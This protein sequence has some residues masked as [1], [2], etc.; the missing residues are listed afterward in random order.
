MSSIHNNGQHL[1]EVMD[2]SL[3][4][5]S[6]EIRAFRKRVS[7]EKNGSIVPNVLLLPTPPCSL[8]KNT[9]I[10]IECDSLI[11]SDPTSNPPETKHPLTSTTGTVMGVNLDL[12]ASEFHLTTSI[13]KATK[14]IN[15][16]KGKT[17][18]QITEILYQLA[19]TGNINEAIRQYYV[20]DETT[21]FALIRI[22]DD[23]ETIAFNEQIINQLK[24]NSL[25]EEFSLA[26]IDKLLET[27]ETKR[28]KLKKLF[29]LSQ[30]ESGPS[31]IEDAIVTK[32][33]LKDL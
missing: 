14:N 11:E 18:A 16:K 19:H 20:T 32:L 17:K 15:A 33:A 31:T 8:G 5:N 13:Y 25:V 29:K 24:A 6:I 26:D 9:S 23:A 30:F 7:H 10:K 27:D 2:V 3:D 28:E 1:V 12:V 4:S 21:E 22:S